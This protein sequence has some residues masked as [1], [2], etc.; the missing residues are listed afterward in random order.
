M[1][2]VDV[3]AIERWICYLLAKQRLDPALAVMPQISNGLATILS[4]RLLLH[5]GGE[6][7]DYG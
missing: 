6:P 7:M 4:E 5:L 3:V 2:V 1:V